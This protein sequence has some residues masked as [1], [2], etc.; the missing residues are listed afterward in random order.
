MTILRK[1]KLEN[2][3]EMTPKLNEWLH[4][5]AGGGSSTLV[6]PRTSWIEKMSIRFLKQPDSIKVD[7]TGLGGFVLERCNGV[8]N[9]QEIADQLAGQYGEEAE[10]VL[11]RL[12]KYLEIVEM[13]GWITW[14]RGQ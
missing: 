5:N 1:K 7:V 6:V 2:I 10:P 9:V 12:V 3:L 11:P 8:H 13:N 4:L 14:K